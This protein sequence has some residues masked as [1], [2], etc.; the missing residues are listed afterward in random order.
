MLWMKKMCGGLTDRTTMVISRSYVI[1]FSNAIRL[2]RAKCLV[3]SVTVIGE[4]TIIYN[5]FACRL[6]LPPVFST[7]RPASPLVTR[8]PNAFAICA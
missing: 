6:S 8:R 1:Q 7:G 2:T 5:N 4:T 3:F